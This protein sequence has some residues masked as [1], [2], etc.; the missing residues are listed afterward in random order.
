MESNEL[1]FF[2]FIFFY[3]VLASCKIYCLRKNYFCTK[4]VPRN[5]VNRNKLHKNNDFMLY[6]AMKSIE[7]T[8]KKRYSNIVTNIGFQMVAGRCGYMPCWVDTFGTTLDG[9]S[10]YQDIVSGLSGR[11]DIKDES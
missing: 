7:N 5:Q 3:M 1:T 11:L 2:L 8:T 9:S 4:T 6:S 10:V